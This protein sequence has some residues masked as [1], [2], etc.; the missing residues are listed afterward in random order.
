MSMSTPVVGIRP[1]DD[2]WKAHKAVWDACIKAGV[3]VPRKTLD[4]FEGESPDD[5]GVLVGI[6]DGPAVSEWQDDC[7]QGFEVDISS[8]PEGIKRIRFY[9]SW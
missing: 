9:N 4:F 3:D 2:A 7:S 8:L 5:A 6:D 1:P